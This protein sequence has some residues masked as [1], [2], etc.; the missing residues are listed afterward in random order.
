MKNAKRW[1]IDLETLDRA[2]EAVRGH[3]KE[4][5][6]ERASALGDGVW[7]KLETEQH[8]GSFK[9]RGA[10]S[11]LATVDAREVVTASAGNHG[12]GLARAG[13]TLGVTVTVFVSRYAPEVKRRGMADAG[14]RVQLVQQRAYD[15]VE[16]A[17]R[18]SAAER[19]VPFVSPFDDPVVAAGNGGTLAR[20]LLRACPDAAT[21]VAPV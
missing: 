1:R 6:L 5:P 14:A 16:A 21:V 10:L 13:A 19:G 9:F 11:K 3:A 7:L 12:Y 17:A 2:M 8:T 18:A 15:D 20:E 4:T